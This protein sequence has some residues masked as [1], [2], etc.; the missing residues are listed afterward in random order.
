MTPFAFQLKPEDEVAQLVD[1]MLSG[2]I[3]R[4]VVCDQAGRPVGIVTSM[5][6]VRDYRRLLD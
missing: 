2:G 5:D 4:V 6:I 3:H 1:T